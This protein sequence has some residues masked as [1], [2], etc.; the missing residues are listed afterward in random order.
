V[1]GSVENGAGNV[2]TRS[3]GNVENGTGNVENRAGNVKKRS[4][5]NVECVGGNV[6]KYWTLDM[7]NFFH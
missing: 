5:G 4:R 1:A 3:R 2:K 7:V 6:E